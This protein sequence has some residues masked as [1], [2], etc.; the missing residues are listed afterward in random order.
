MQKKIVYII[1]F[2]FF[3]LLASCV[4]NKKQIIE[5]VNAPPRIIIQ[6]N[7]DENTTVN[8]VYLLNPIIDNTDDF[9]KKSKQDSTSDNVRN[10][11]SDDTSDIVLDASTD[12]NPDVTTDRVVLAK[13][14]LYIKEK[15]KV[16][17]YKKMFEKIRENIEKTFFIEFKNKKFS[18]E[19]YR[20]K[21]D[22]SSADD[23]LIDIRIC[24]YEEG[25]YNLILNRDTKIR[26]DVKIINYNEKVIAN[27]SKNYILKTNYDYP[28]EIL[29][30]SQINTVFIREFTTFLTKVFTSK[31]EK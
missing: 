7:Y 23:L 3:I 31:N 11:N 2:V 5:K 26:Y 15:E 19:L 10:N 18:I 25:E 29:R 9:I 28:L 13:E 6:V 1:G 27:F 24:D 17:F 22:M 21:I 20:D 4:T 16:L 8:G 12:I 30:L 14:K